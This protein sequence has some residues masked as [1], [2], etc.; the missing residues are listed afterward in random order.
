MARRNEGR[1]VGKPQLWER[2][3]PWAW[4]PAPAELD[5]EEELRVVPEPR[6]QAVN[7]GPDPLR[8][9]ETRVRRCAETGDSRKMAKEATWGTPVGRVDMVGIM[10]ANRALRELA[11]REARYARVRVTFTDHTGDVVSQQEV[12]PDMIRWEPLT[13]NGTVQVNT[14]MLLRG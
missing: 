13:T 9:G 10:E 6:R 3:S 2:T 14:A 5:D 1:H 12:S 4:R 8:L 11:E 7:Y